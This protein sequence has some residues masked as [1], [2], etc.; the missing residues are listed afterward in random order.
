MIGVGE[1][2]SNATDSE[3]NRLY[4]PWLYR[5]DPVWNELGVYSRTHYNRTSGL[6]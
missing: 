6:A 4:P 1:T 3:S 2:S 5:R